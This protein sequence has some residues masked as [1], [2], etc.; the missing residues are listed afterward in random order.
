V[1]D[2]A[3]RT[4]LIIPA[5]LMSIAVDKG[6]EQFKATV[7]AESAEIEPDSRQSPTP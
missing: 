6:M 2:H 5:S 7:G 1:Q 3:I 4:T